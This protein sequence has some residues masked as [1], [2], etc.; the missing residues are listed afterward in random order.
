MDRF[1]F[2]IHP[3][4]FT[5][6]YHFFPPSRLFP[7]FL[8][9]K[10]LFNLSPFLARRAKD[11]RSVSGNVVEGYFI[12]CPLL[13]EQILGLEEEVLFDKVMAAARLAEKLGAKILGIGA[14]A[15]GIGEANQKIAEQLEIGVTN[16]TS[17]AGAAVIETARRAARIKN[18]DLR[19]AKVAIIGATNP[20]GKICAYDLSKKVAQLSLVA[21]NQE[22]LALLADKLKDNVPAAIENCGLNLRGAIDD[23]EVIIFT[24]AALEVTPRV[25]L[26]DLRQDAIICDIPAP[27]NITSDMARLRPDLLIIDGAAVELPHPI[28]LNLHLG[29]ADGQVYACMAETMILALEGS[30][31][32]FS[33]GWEPAL[34]KV[35]SISRLAQKHGFKPA[36]TS[37]GKKIA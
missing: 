18:F 21:K 6:V 5:D 37:F 8:V 4:D 22:R 19:G 7:K 27:R 2:I 29:L 15:S 20:I 30:F 26:E 16:G 31:G 1:G 23:A 9:K 28:R 25:R 17:L 10:V 13:S 34:D 33:I 24:T 14:L 11:I 3:I 32:D 36:F 12:V 35:E